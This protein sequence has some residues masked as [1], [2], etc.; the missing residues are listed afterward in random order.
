MGATNALLYA[1]IENDAENPDFITGNQISRIGII[2]NPKS[3]GSDQLLTLDKASAA[4]GLRLSGTGYSSVTFTPD[5]LIQ[6]TVGTGVTAYGKV[7]AYDQTT[8][9]LK[10]WQD[11]T[12]AG[13]NTVG[14]AQT[15][16]AA[17]YGY[18]TTR[19]TADPDSGGNVTI[20]GGSSN[21]SISTTF[22]GLST[23]INNRT[24]YLG[25]TFTKG[26]SNPEIDKYSG[27]MIYVDNRPS[28]TRSS[29]QKEDVKIILQF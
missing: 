26:V 17:I 9:V 15:A 6:Q 22:T 1:R 11:R 24:Y 5:S 7:I 19:F 29:N 16:T 10:Y 20:V 14:T 23:S 28:I 25:Q 18:N 27:N 12:I 3:F 13:F 21:L 2:E 8:G 4:Y